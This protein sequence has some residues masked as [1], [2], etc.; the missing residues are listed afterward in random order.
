ML[1]NYQSPFFFQ[2]L[3]Y[4]NKKENLKGRLP[5]FLIILLPFSE[6]LLELCRNSFLVLSFT[7]SF[8]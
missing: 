1:S 3:I 8:Q 7:V 4:Y 6:I 5:L 2:K